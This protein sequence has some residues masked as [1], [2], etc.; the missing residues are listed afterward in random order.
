V[1]RDA[2]PSERKGDP[3]RPHA[4]LER[5]S[6]AGEAGEELN[7]R[8]DDGVVEHALRGHVVVGG[9]RFVEVAVVV[10]DRNLHRAR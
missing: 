6:L 1:H 10:H 7:G 9:D 3:P 4:E 2:P 8:S 5:P